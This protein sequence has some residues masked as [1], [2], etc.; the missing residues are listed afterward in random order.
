MVRVLLTRLYR[1]LLPLPLRH[2]PLHPLHL[3]LLPVYAFVPEQLGETGDHRIQFDAE[4]LTRD[5]AFVSARHLL[6]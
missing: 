5:L 1:R 2:H 6:Q 4:I 3:R